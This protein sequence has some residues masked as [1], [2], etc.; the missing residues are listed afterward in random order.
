MLVSAGG[1]ESDRTRQVT[2][3]D[4]PSDS[5]DVASTLTATCCARS[6]AVNAAHGSTRCSQLSRT[7][8]VGSSGSVATS[9]SMAEVPGA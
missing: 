9:C 4:T 8:S 2:S 3:P 5:R 7:I 6:A 1:V